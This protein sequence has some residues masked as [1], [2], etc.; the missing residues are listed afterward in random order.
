MKSVARSTATEIRANAATLPD[1]K[2]AP[3]Q[4]QC[5]EN[6]DGWPCWRRLGPSHGA[7][8]HHRRPRLREGASSPA[9]QPVPVSTAPESANSSQ[10]P[11]STTTMT[12]DKVA[13]IARTMAI[14]V[15]TIPITVCVMA[16]I[17]Q[18]SP[19]PDEDSLFYVECSP[20]YSLNQAI[21]GEP[22]RVAVAGAA[23][24]EATGYSISTADRGIAKTLLP[25]PPSRAIPDS[26]AARSCPAS[27]RPRGG[28]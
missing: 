18:E 11:A 13:R 10:N 24:G 25:R 4:A 19:L 15:R 5:V 21:S 28:N 8:H 2:R 16:S 20:F 17:R 6:S 23:L 3:R 14:P 7:F 22:R 1:F 26:I 12:A 27:L 9:T